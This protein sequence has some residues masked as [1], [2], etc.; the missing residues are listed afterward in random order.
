MKKNIRKTIIPVL[1]LLLAAS[2]I[3]A[4]KWADNA[5]STIDFNAIMFYI[6]E[7]LQGTNMGAF[8]GLFLQLCIWSPIVAGLMLLP[9]FFTNRIYVLEIKFKERMHLIGFDWYRRNLSRVSV[10][11]LMIAILYAANSLDVYGYV[12]GYFHA[13]SIY[14][15]YYIDPENVALSFPETKRNLI[16][17]FMESMENTYMS[18][19]AGGIEY[20]NFISEMTELQQ[21]NENF[22]VSDTVNGGIATSGATWTMGAMV[23]QT[24]GIPLSIPIGGNE[25]DKGFDSFLP[26]A[27]SLGQILEEQ[28]Y[29]QVFLVGSDAAFGGRDTYLTQ[30]GNYQIKDYNYAIEHNWIEEDYYVWWGYEDE[31]LYS[32]AKKEL[33]ELADAGEPFNLTMLTVDTHFFDGY[34]CDLCEN[35]FGVDHYADVIACAS[36]QV[37]EFVEWIQK[38]DFYENTTIIICGDHPTMDENYLNGSVVQDLSTYQRKVY[39]TIVNSACEYTL[40]YDRTFTTMDMY[41]TTL[42]SLGVEIEGNRLALGTNLYADEPTLVERLGID[43]LN[44]EL[45]K[46]SKYYKRNILYQKAGK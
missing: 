7:P 12:Y 27:Y 31:K 10:L 18:E 5:F 46:T 29:Q 22:A 21:K 35:T 32:F 15:D 6:R 28:G 34:Y 24:A 26:G 41:P 39:T 17:I 30:H 37:T 16:Y 14:E 42:A 2:I 20:G 25:M 3:V 19:E 45:E 36:R 13:S 33:L 1:L 4:V 8:Q 9:A 44:G 23:A 43:S 11:W 40:D 38:Q